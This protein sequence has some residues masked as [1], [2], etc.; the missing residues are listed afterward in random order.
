MFSTSKSRLNIGSSDFSS[1]H[2]SRILSSIQHSIYCILVFC[3]AKI[4]TSHT[5]LLISS[6]PT[7]FAIIDIY[8][9]IEI[10]L[11]MNVLHI[12]VSIFTMHDQIDTNIL[13]N[14]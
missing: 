14:T 8:K 1:N 2:D 5:A 12:F 4:P 10:V 7:A 9:P 11:F 13:V 3:N 6:T